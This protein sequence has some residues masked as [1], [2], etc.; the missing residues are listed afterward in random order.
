MNV[1]ITNQPHEEDKSSN[2]KY[3]ALERFLSYIRIKLIA[4]NK[5]DLALLY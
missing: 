5:L 1:K 3:L 4:E 2:T